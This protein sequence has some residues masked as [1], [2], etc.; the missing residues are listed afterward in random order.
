MGAK[1]SKTAPLSSDT[2]LVSSYQLRQIHIPF[3][4]ALEYDNLE[5]NKIKKELDF[6]IVP[7]INESISHFLLRATPLPA[8][9]LFVPF[10]Y[11]IS[12]WNPERAGIRLVL[13]RRKRATYSGRWECRLTLSPFSFFLSLCTP[14]RKG[15]FFFETLESATQ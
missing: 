2:T 14:S 10:P 3:N 1:L 6:S 4:F 8:P 9:S 15:F 13:S 5:E 7:Y 12:L 11:F